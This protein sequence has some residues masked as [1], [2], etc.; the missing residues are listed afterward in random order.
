MSDFFSSQVE[1]YNQNPIIYDV[2]DDDMKK[3]VEVDLSSSGIGIKDSNDNNLQPEIYLYNNEGVKQNTGINMNINNTTGKHEVN[4]IIK[5]SNKMTINDDGVSGSLPSEL[6][7]QTGATSGSLL[8]TNGINTTS[9]TNS[10]TLAVINSSSG[11]L[12]GLKFGSNTGV[13]GTSSGVNLRVNGVTIIGISSSTI[14]PINPINIIHSGSANNP[15]LSFGDRVTA[16]GIYASPQNDTL[17][18]CTGGVERMKMENT[19]I[20]ISNNLNVNGS[21]VLMNPSTS[22]IISN[23]L[24]SGNL[25]FGNGF[26][27]LSYSTNYIETN[28]SGTDVNGN[29]NVFGFISCPNVSN[30]TEIISASSTTAYV[31]NSS[32]TS[33]ATTLITTN[34]SAQKNITLDNLGVSYDGFKFEFI[35]SG[36]TNTITGT[37]INFTCNLI[38]TVLIHRLGVVITST[39]GQTSSASSIY[40]NLPNNARFIGCFV[41]NNATPYWIIRDVTDYQQRLSNIV[42][43]DPITSYT[44]TRNTP[45]IVSIDRTSNRIIVLTNLTTDNGTNTNNYGFIVKI[46]CYGLPTTGAVSFTNYSGSDVEILS[47]NVSRGVISNNNTLSLISA[48]G[49]S[50]TFKCIFKENASGNYQ[51]YIYENQ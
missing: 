30:K 16:S 45:Q 27:R 44:I 7:I 20:T 15:S 22:V 36:N 18:F 40:A 47:S 43:K 42:V 9:W 12:G 32:N 38:N 48:S 29:L 21:I 25:S 51:W 8:Q 39:V 1:I 3:Y 14:T 41:W 2:I 50:K 17:N 5:G 28:S 10:P 6:P 46:Q 35:F 37:F 34:A 4:F 19:A 24:N 49:V 33:P 31:Y 26:P 11:A 13:D 23:I